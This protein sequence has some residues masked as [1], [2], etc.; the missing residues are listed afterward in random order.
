VVDLIVSLWLSEQQI[1][2]STCEDAYLA[3]L[4][5]FYASLDLVQTDSIEKGIFCQP[6]SYV[7]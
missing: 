1:R 5:E 6:H 4:T 7:H 3:G 2:D